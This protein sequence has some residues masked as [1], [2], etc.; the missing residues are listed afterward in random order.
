MLSKTPDN[1]FFHI[2]LNSDGEWDG[3]FSDT[4]VFENYDDAL[5][6][7]NNVTAKGLFQIEKYFMN[8]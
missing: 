3:D 7:L 8:Q 2:Y 4:N 1:K 5:A 6:T